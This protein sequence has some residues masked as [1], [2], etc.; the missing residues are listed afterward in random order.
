MGTL[1]TSQTPRCFWHPM[2]RTSLPALRCR[3]MAARSSTSIELL[4]GSPVIIRQQRLPFFRTRVEKFSERQ[5]YALFRPARVN[6]L[7][8]QLRHARETSAR[9]FSASAHPPGSS[10][11]SFC[12]AP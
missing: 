9:P 2:R 8:P 12:Q 4:A 6:G 3:S 1:G 7:V 5:S 11:W 10:R